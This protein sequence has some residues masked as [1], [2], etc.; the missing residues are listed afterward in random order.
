MGKKMTSPTIS[1]R[2]EG[3]DIT[4]SQSPAAS[5]WCAGFHIA[6]LLSVFLIP[7][8]GLPAFRPMCPTNFSLCQELPF[9]Y[10]F[11]KKPS[12]APCLILSPPFGKKNPITVWDTE[13]NAYHACCPEVW[14]FFGISS[15]E[16]VFSFYSATSQLLPT[17]LL[18]WACK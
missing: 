6:F 7:W 5:W 11:L 15:T 14:Y 2:R 3:S 4:A 10:P 13:S 18:H 17:Q 1:R 16:I 12:F 8:P 9:F